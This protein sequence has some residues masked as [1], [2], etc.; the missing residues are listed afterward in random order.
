MCGQEEQCGPEVKPAL[1]PG[2]GQEESCGPEVKPALG[3][4]QEAADQVYLDLIP[5][6]SFLHT[7]G[8][9]A[10]PLKDVSSPTAAPAEGPLDPPS[11]VSHERECLGSLDVHT[12]C[13]NSV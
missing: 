9:S 7:S 4:G 3:P 2:Q 13:M 5:V 12:T 1:G 8:G 6:R 11:T 10:C